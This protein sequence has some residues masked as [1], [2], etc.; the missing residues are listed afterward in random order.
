MVLVSVTRIQIHA[1][2]RPAFLLLTWLIARQVAR[3]PGYLGGRLLASGQGTY[4]TVTAWD[5]EASMRRFRDRGRHATGLR[6]SRRWAGSMDAARYEADSAA[7]AGWDDAA[8]RLGHPTPGG[9][10]TGAEV[11]IASKA[12]A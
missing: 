5:D 11:I 10:G 9:V 12:R 6:R 4:W 1:V 7:F 8:R 2:W 3:S